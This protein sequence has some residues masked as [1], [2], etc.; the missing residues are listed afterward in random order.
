MKIKVF[1]PNE[2]GHIELTKEKLEDLLNEAYNEGYRDGSNNN[3]YYCGITTTPY[4]SS[5][6]KPNIAYL[7]STTP[8]LGTVDKAASSAISCRDSVSAIDCC[9]NTDAAASS[10]ISCCGKV[11]STTND[12]VNTDVKI[13]AIDYCINNDGIT[14]DILE[15]KVKN[16]IIVEYAEASNEA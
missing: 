12:C 16:A 9:V 6:S 8:S 11:T 5:I 4:V 14:A 2:K 13:S 15:G 1:Y 10:A 7:S 3:G